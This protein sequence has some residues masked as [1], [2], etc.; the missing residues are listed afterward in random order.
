M[1]LSEATV[2][3]SVIF[4]ETK[5]FIN[6]FLSLSRTSYAEGLGAL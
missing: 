5:Q 4:P 3:S 6:E 1:V 2:T